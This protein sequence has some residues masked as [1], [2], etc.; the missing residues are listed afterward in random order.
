MFFPSLYEKL[1]EL[2]IETGRTRSQLA[3]W[4]LEKALKKELQQKEENF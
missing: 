1:G 2:A 4:L 3:G